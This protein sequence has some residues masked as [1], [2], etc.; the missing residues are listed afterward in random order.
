MKCKPNYHNK[1]RQLLI[2]LYGE[3][4]SQPDYI[5]YLNNE[6]NKRLK[7]KFPDNIQIVSIHEFLDF[8]GLDSSFH[9]DAGLKILVNNLKGLVNDVNELL[10]ARLNAFNKIKKFLKLKQLADESWEY[11]EDVP[12]DPH[13]LGQL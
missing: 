1:D 12:K 5:K 6:K 7:G 3:R 8:L 13:Y 2:V 11:L 4:A 10:T 9:Q